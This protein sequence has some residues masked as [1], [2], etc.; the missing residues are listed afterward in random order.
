MR[1]FL[2]P[3][4]M[5]KLLSG[6][7]KSKAPGSTLSAKSMASREEL[8][9]IVNKRNERTLAGW[10][11]NWVYWGA[12]NRQAVTELLAR[13]SA[14]ISN[15]HI[16]PA[17][18]RSRV[19]VAGSG[20]S[21]EELQDISSFDGVI[22]ATTSSASWLIT[23]GRAPDIV[24]AADSHY[25]QRA[26]LQGIDKYSRMKMSVVTHPLVHP[27]LLNIPYY[28]YYLYIPY[29]ADRENWETENPQ[30]QVIKAMYPDIETYFAM[31]GST[32]NAGLILVQSLIQQE[33]LPEW[34]IV[35]IAGFDFAGRAG[36]QDHATWYLFGDNS[37]AYVPQA[38]TIAH[39]DWDNMN[40][41]ESLMRTLGGLKMAIRD[42]HPGRGL[43]QPIR[44]LR[45]PFEQVPEPFFKSSDALTKDEQAQL[46]RIREHTAG[47]SDGQRTALLERYYKLVEEDLVVLRQNKYGPNMNSPNSNGSN[48]TNEQNPNG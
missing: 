11:K 13:R 21:L 14:Q 19:L 25:V 20:T 34:P 33:V 7:K 17:R 22:I 4:S 6:N 3:P 32:G 37:R 8:L 48:N 15:L 29:I 1:C 45:L 44:S 27:D 2:A 47:M 16:D 38:R 43:D 31:S 23:H 9:D 41:R 40:Y 10:W 30:N 35:T 24:I 36:E 39:V 5:E 28:V 26:R 46:N 12:Q 18:D 42:F